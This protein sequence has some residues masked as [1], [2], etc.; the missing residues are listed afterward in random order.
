M[1]PY[2]D[3]I[4]IAFK[5]R[6]EDFSFPGFIYIFL[7]VSGGLACGG[8]EKGDGKCSDQTSR[9]GPQSTK[10]RVHSSLS[11]AMGIAVVAISVPLRLPAII[12]DSTVLALRAEALDLGCFVLT[13]F[14]IA[15]WAAVGTCKECTHLAPSA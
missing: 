15:F 11:G 9:K 2:M 13:P 12:L 3:G 1:H 5:K 8:E 10:T 7:C 14:Q 6:M 4:N